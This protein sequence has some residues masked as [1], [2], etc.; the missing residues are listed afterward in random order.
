MSIFNRSQHDRDLDAEVQSHLQMAA[1]DRVE[2]GEATQD[3]R[4]AALREFGNISMVKEATREIWG[5]STLERL[6]QDLRYGARTLRKTPGFALVAVLSLALGIGGNATVFSWVQ[7]VLL[8]PL[9]GVPH[10]DRLVAIESIMPD[11]EYHTSSYPDYRDFRDQS[12][13]FSGMVGVELVG[14]NLRLQNETHPQRDWGELVTENFFDVLGVH[15]E[16]GRMFEPADAQGLNSDPLVVL[17]YGFWQRRFAADA[18]IIGKTIEINR[19]S[20]TVIGIAPRGF[21]GA[22][23]GIAAEY[24]VPMMMQPA[25]LPGEDLE[26]R[27]PTFI[28][29]IGRLKPEASLQQASSELHTI[30]ARLQSQYPANSKNVGVY[31]CPLWEAHYGLQAFLLPVLSFLMIVVALVLL[32]ACANVANLLLARATVR[33]R[34][35]AVRAALG[36]SRSR[37]VRQLLSESLL[38]ALLGGGLGIL[39]AYASTNWLMFFLPPAHLPIGLPLAIDGRIIVFT[40]ALTVLTAFV[41]GL[42]PALQTSRPNMNRALQEG[43]RT[44]SASAGR[45]RLR[46][47][48]VVSETVLAVMLLVGAG[49]LV[50][51]FRAAEASSPGFNPNNVLLTAMDLRGNGYTGAQAA[52]FYDRLIQQLRTVPGV[53]A[54]SLERW[55]PMWFT[56]RGYTRPT[57]EGYTFRR[58]EEHEIDYNVVGQEYFSTMQIPLQRGRDFSQRD[59]R[60]SQLVCIVNESMAKRFWPGQDPIGHR[61]NSWDRWW[62]VVG[63]VKDIKYHSMNERPESFLYFPMSQDTS[64]TDANILVRTAGDPMQ[65][66]SAVR[67][68]VHALDAGATIIDSDDLSGLLSVSLFTYRVAATLSSILGLLGLLLASIGLY[69]VLSYS[70]SQRRQEIGIR[71]ALG[72]NRKDV[73]R[74]VVSAGLKLTL[75]GIA[76][77]I[78]AAL[79][80]S[81]ALRSLLFGVRST[82]PVTLMAVTIL[83]LC[84]GLIACYLPARRAMAVDPIVALRHE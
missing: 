66:L 57:V 26:E 82:D 37:L 11:G 13:A 32:I 14:T 10:S 67:A 16:Q 53:Q 59:N 18:T 52:A 27:S 3:A 78:F 24:W 8:H 48:L 80:F 50:R 68:Q 64:G 19:H 71:M 65:L 33:E 47:L 25:A 9:A 60:D 84:V 83:L 35:I 43:G 42:A 30:S 21:R 34:E 72:A 38:L 75:L 81:T 15:A 17:S 29:I 73:L 36:A 40:V 70:V 77:G 58:D 39:L 4:D 7:A 56:G 45:R 1:Q 28:H 55:V 23:V 12:R 41:F 2:Q 79:A 6:L 61:L 5:G 63:V 49:L 20:F 76:A 44:A 54:A 51:S 69:G 74:L 46:N 62:T 22:I 31:V